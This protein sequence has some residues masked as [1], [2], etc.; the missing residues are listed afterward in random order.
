M[1][2]YDYLKQKCHQKRIGIIKNLI[3][4]YSKEGSRI[5]SIGCGN[6]LIE[7]EFSRTVQGLD[8]APIKNGLISITNGEIEKMPFPDDSFDVVFA[9]ELL[10]H[11]YDI[12]QAINEV[13]R[14]LVND[15]IVIF[16]VP[17]AMNFRDRVRGLFGILPR[18]LSGYL[19]ENPHLYEH[20]RHFN[21]RSLKELLEGNG[22]E[23]L[24]FSSPAININIFGKTAIDLY[25]P[26]KYIPSLGNNIVC[27]ARLSKA[28]K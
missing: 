13:K 2:N 25:R 18:Q 4:Q 15:G 23:C 28:G 1:Y 27:V 11:I 7:K 20:I 24:E 26:A 8:K 10:E 16:T 12:K 22:F 21:K 14:V 6:G 17:N 9:G 19:D 3:Q 5:L